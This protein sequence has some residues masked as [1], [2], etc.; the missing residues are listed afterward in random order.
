MS[1]S[2]FLAPP[3]AGRRCEHGG[4]TAGR[5]RP[6]ATGGAFGMSTAASRTGY[7]R[8]RSE[9]LHEDAMQPGIKTFFDEATFTAT[10]VVWDPGTR[11]AAI[12][13]SVKDYDPKS[14]RIAT[15][16]KSTRLNSSQ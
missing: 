5:Q 3:T 15:N 2:S 16:R 7:N 9:T 14:G 6:A 10:H 4:R 13:D 8:Q 12:I 1:R 11:R